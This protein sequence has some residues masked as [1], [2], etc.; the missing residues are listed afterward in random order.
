LAA[1]KRE[2]SKVSLDRH[3]LQRNL[4]I[5]DFVSNAAVADKY[6]CMESVHM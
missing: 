2:R 1:Q 3:H 5:L 6:L 4:S